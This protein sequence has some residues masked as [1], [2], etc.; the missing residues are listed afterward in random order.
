[1]KRIFTTVI[2]SA[3]I[4]TSFSARAQ[5]K[6]YLS[7]FGGLSNPEGLY[8][9]TDYS[10]NQ[11]GFAKK[12]A[13]VGID[14]AV[15]VY[16]NLGIGF[17]FSFQDQGKLNYNDTYA[18]AQ[19]YTASYTAD[20]ATV[21]AYDRYQNWNLLIGPQY[22]FTYHSFILDLRAYGGMVDVTSTPETKVTLDGIPE[23]TAPFYERRGHGSMFGY[24]A[25][26]GLR[27]KLGDSWTI[28]VKG[29]YIGASG[30]NIKVDGLSDN[31]NGRYVTKIPLKE[32]QTTF[33]IGLNF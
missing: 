22:S 18:L 19:G 1:M 16:K 24:G 23:Q 21:D 13:T 15:Y 11:S 26:A 20:Q 3:I 4:L 30:P 27:F 7:L 29:A 10:N 33:G 9:S 5:V 12:G 2:L 17:T 25:S 31:V 6:S 8:K 28:G 14:G 32:F